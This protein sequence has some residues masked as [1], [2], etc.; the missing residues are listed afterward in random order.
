MLFYMQLMPL[1]P[2]CVYHPSS[3]EVVTGTPL[4]C[5]DMSLIIRDSR[6][7]TELGVQILVYSHDRSDITATV[8][9]VGCRPN[10]HYRVLGEMILV[11]V[12][13]TLVKS[14]KSLNTL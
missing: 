5:W 12:S 13:V 10:S 8:A 11:M 1:S 3:Q 9:V 14:E 6:K 7:D 4:E 2:L